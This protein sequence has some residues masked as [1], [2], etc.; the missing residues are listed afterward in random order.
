MKILQPKFC[1]L[2][3][4]HFDQG[5]VLPL[6]RFCLIFFANNSHRRKSLK[7]T[8]TY[9]YEIH[10]LQKLQKYCMPGWLELGSCN[11]HGRDGDRVCVSKRERER[12][13]A[14]N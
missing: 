7:A 14:E 5:F 11:P 13:E 2:F 6:V 9:C 8:A 10:F 12:E 4:H 1:S 3:S